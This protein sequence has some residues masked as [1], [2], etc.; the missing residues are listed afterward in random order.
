MKKTKL[1]LLLAL[2]LA[3]TVMTTSCSKDDDPGNDLIG[4]WKGVFEY[5]NTI[6]Q[7]NADGTLFRSF[8]DDRNGWEYQDNNEYTV[9]G[10]SLRIDFN[11][12]NNVVD[13]YTIGTYTINDNTLT[14]VYTWH[15]GQGK[16]DHDDEHITILTR[17]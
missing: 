14:Y 8:E 13:D 5:E 15:D 4:K 1:S 17:M 9:N 3:P 10:S 2:M 7:F 6:F 16:W 11:I 12:E